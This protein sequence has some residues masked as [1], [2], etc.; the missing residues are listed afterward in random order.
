MGNVLVGF[1]VYIDDDDED[2]LEVFD[3]SD[4][5]L[6]D[7][8]WWNF[9]IYKKKKYNKGRFGGGKRGRLRRVDK[10]N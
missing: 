1:R 4:L 3:F 8:D 7:R 5:D 9:G 2:F 6:F 10:V